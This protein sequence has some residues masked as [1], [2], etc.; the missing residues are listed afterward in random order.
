MG[1]STWRSKC[2]T[3]LVK[4]GEVLLLPED[5]GHAITVRRVEVPRWRSDGS[6]RVPAGRD[7]SVA[8]HDD[9]QDFPIP[10]S[11]DRLIGPTDMGE[12]G[13]V[14]SFLVEQNRIMGRNEFTVVDADQGPPWILPDQ[15]TNHLTISG[16]VVRIVAHEH[17]SAIRVGGP[18][19]NNA[20]VHSSRLS[21]YWRPG[22]SCKLNGS[23]GRNLWGGAV[24]VR[25]RAPTRRGSPWPASGARRRLRRS[26]R[27]RGRRSRGGPGR[28][29]SCG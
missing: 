29:R 19:L 25:T 21:G 3:S 13:Q 24:R 5:L 4:Y 23:D 1:S 9:K 6:R 14:L 11:M 17:N 18:P 27:C 26:W 2:A 20:A 10:E 8:T 28:S 15:S 7:V 16:G 12:D 22:P